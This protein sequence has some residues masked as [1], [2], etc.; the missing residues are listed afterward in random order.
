MLKIFNK[1]AHAL[2]IGF[3]LLQQTTDAITYAQD[4]PKFF[5]STLDII[6]LPQMVVKALHL[7]VS[8]ML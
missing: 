4:S 3:F 5:I 2:I 1:M 8:K 7:I 6:K